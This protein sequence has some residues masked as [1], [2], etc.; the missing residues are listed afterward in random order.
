M[1]FAGGFSGV[2]RRDGLQPYLVCCILLFLVCEWIWRVISGT[3]RAIRGHNFKTT[4]ISVSETITNKLLRFIWV[5]YSGRW[6]FCG[7][8]VNLCMIISCCPYL[9]SAV[10][11]D[12][13]RVELNME[14]ELLHNMRNQEAMIAQQ[15]RRTHNP[16]VKIKHK[17]QYYYSI[18]HKRIQSCVSLKQIKMKFNKPLQHLQSNQSSV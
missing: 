1:V 7:R 8:H 3:M 10:W 4:R 6:V 2:Q 18:R 12:M 9:N 15:T 16:R 14:I 11:M 17:E 5:T 13:E